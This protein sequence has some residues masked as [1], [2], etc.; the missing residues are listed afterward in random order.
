MNLNEKLEELERAFSELVRKSP[1]TPAEMEEIERRRLA[2]AKALKE[3]SQPL[4]DDFR[5][6]GIDASVSDLVNTSEKYPEAIPLLV[7]HLRRPYHRAIKEGIVRALAVKEAKGI[8]NE[9]VIEEYRN[10]PREDPD[11]PW[12]YHYRWALG[13]TMT[14]IV[15]EDDLDDLIEIVTDESNGDSRDSFV[16]ALGKL[17]SPKVA[18][19]LNRL[20]YDKSKLVAE[21]ARRILNKK[22][23]IW[24]RK[25]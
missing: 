17:K 21:D 10:L 14:V 9:A 20:V 16:I 1:K 15:T 11:K 5:V 13:N 24:M 19:V 3:H 7:K 2:F 22:K 8:A 6:V 18:E 12:I 25:S 4:R 23:A